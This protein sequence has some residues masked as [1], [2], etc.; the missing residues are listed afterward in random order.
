MREDRQEWFDVFVCLHAFY[1]SAVKS[2][3]D[4]FQG[5]IADALLPAD[6]LYWKADSTHDNQLNINIYKNFANLPFY[7][8]CHAVYC[9]KSS[10][11][12]IRGDEIETR[13]E[14]KLMERG[15]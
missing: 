2:F 11:V 1:K 12:E 4:P 13:R 9:P 3:T 8:I 14:R 6:S 7:L 5:Y 10:G 15:L